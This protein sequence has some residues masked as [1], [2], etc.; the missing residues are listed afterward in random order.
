MLYFLL[1]IS[2]LIESWHLADRQRIL[3]NSLSMSELN[4]FGEREKTPRAPTTP[5]RCPPPR[6]PETYR[7]QSQPVRAHTEEPPRRETRESSRGPS[8]KLLGFLRRPESKK[9]QPESSEMNG[10]T[11]GGGM[12]DQAWD[13]KNDHEKELLEVAAELKWLID[14]NSRQLTELCYEEA[15]RKS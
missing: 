6:P 7:R 8:S 9:K 15:V 5:T 1:E 10:S 14:E 12:E 11:R 4:A 3:D 13:G 2:Q